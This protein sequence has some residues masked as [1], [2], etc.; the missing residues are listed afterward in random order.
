MKIVIDNKIVNV[1][2]DNPSKIVKNVIIS[3]PD[4]YIHFGWA[5]LLEYLRLG[6]LFSALPMFG[7]GYALYEATLTVLYENEEKDVL[8]YMY[9][10]L[11]TE[12]LNQ[13]KAL[14]Q[15][16]VS[17]I[18]NAIKIQREKPSFLEAE[19][20]IS[21][22]LEVYEAAFLDK[23][24]DTMHD[25][26]LYLAWDR[27]CVYTSRLFNHQ[28]ADSKFTKGI[29]VLKECLIES[30]Q[31]ISKQEHTRPSLFRLLE[32]LFFYHMR[33]ENL[34][35]HTAV[36]WA[37]L[38]QGFSALKEQNELADNFYIDDVIT[39]DTLKIEE[40]YSTCYLTLDSPESVN[41]RIALA[42]CMLNKLQIDGLQWKYVLKPQKI[43]YLN[44]ESC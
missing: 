2:F 16:N 34:Q 5:S 11:F 7:Q 14:P 24:Y 22:I 35:K 26:I 13:I 44:L 38:S 39:E 3:N 18:L 42:Q 4:N 40:E 6:S 30:Y 25:L 1:F 23:P 9:D 15:I 19:K 36:E 10:R 29:E 43:I 27:M 33:E 31:H 17:F 41:S 12:I 37:V 32:A 28:T 21:P 8:F 20:V